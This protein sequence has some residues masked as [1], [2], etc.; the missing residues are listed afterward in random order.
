MD[1]FHPAC[2]FVNKN[3]SIYQFIPG[4]S[5]LSAFKRERL[6]AK[7]KSAGIPVAN[8]VARYEHHVLSEQTLTEAEQQHLF[9]YAHSRDHPEGVRAFLAGS[10]PVFTGD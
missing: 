5:V 2:F 9:R 8:V 10:E 3:V 6:L 1:A 4:S 7:M